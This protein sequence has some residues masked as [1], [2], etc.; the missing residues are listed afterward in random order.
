MGGGAGFPGQHTLRRWH[1][2]QPDHLEMMRGDGER[3]L[4]GAVSGIERS[5]WGVEE[6][7]A[8]RS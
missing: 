8:A 1:G 3:Q 6:Q 5:M 4:G 2:F 7:R